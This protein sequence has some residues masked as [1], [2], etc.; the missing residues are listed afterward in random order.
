MC[1]DGTGDCEDCREISA[2]LVRS[3]HFTICAKPWNCREGFSQKQRLCQDL[4]TKWFEMRKDYEVAAGT[5]DAAKY[6]GKL[7]G[8]FCK[9]GGD[10]NYIGM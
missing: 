9:G 3:V 10:K 1:R 6:N 2:D 4:H 8:G 5:W 7:Y